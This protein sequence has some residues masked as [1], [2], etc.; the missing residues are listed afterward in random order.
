[1]LVP[2]PLYFALRGTRD[3]E[4]IPDWLA[5]SPAGTNAG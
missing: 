2:I 4:E 1:M 5:A 3:V